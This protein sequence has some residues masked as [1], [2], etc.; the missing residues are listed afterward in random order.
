MVIKNLFE[1]KID[2]L[3]KNIPLDSREKVFQSQSEDDSGYQ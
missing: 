3:D 1:F 2:F